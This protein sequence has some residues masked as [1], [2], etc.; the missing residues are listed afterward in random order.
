MVPGTA[1]VYKTALRGAP[2]ASRITPRGGCPLFEVH[3]RWRD[4]SRGCS[5][6]ASARGAPVVLGIQRYEERR[7]YNSMAVIEPGGAVGA[8]YPLPQSLACL[9]I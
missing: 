6:S 7:I 4:Q 9:T 1:P 2:Y 8:V 3:V 5:V